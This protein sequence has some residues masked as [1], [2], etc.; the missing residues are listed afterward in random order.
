MYAVFILVINWWLHFDPYIH[1]RSL[2]KVG[3]SSLLIFD[4]HSRSLTYNF[5]S[6]SCNKN[7]LSNKIKFT[8]VSPFVTAMST[9]NLMNILRRKYMQFSNK[10]SSMYPFL[11]SWKLFYVETGRFRGIAIEE[12]AC[13]LCNIND[14]EDEMQMLCTWALYQ[15]LKWISLIWR[16]STGSAISHWLLKS[17]PT[18]NEYT[19]LS[20]RAY[21]FYKK[22]WITYIKSYFIIDLGNFKCYLVTFNPN[23]QLFYIRMGVSSHTW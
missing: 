22:Q 3:L 19:A 23:L 6:P 15:Y 17:R 18:I 5:V 21:F 14:I 2:Y 1:M 4:L 7:Q 9:S 11:H 16:N 13:V 10:M 8:L 12:R 20:D